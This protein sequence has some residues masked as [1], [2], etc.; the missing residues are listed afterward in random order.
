MTGKTH[1]HVYFGTLGCIP[2]DNDQFDTLKEAEEFAIAS[3]AELRHAGRPVS[4]NV[5]TGY[6]VDAINRLYVERCTYPECLIEDG[7]HA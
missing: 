7:W 2:D 5:K 4:G 3:A 1:Y 6:D